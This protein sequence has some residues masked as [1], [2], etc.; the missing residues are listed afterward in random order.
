[1]IDA[2]V[3]VGVLAVAG[4]GDDMT[5]IIVGVVVVAVDVEMKEGGI[6]G[7]G[8]TEREFESGIRVGSEVV[9]VPIEVREVEDERL[10]RLE[11]ERESKGG[12]QVGIGRV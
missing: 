8:D 3:D 6:G 11:V 10:E 2:N 12:E 7:K 9:V 4:I 5:G 1:L